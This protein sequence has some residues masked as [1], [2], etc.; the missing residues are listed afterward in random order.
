MAD[1]AP[2]LAAVRGSLT[3]SVSTLLGELDALERIIAEARAEVAALNRDVA[4][5]EPIPA[6][7][8][9]LGAVVEHTAQATHTILDACERLEA[10]EL[11]A[12]DAP[13]RLAEQTTRIYE[14]CAFQDITGQRI[15]KVVN[16]LEAIERRIGRARAGLTTEVAASP[17]LN[18]PQLPG[19]G[20]S[21]S[22]I[23]SLFD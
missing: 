12:A 6:A 18:G 11:G 21:Q 15:A 1:T 16:A 9:E 20:I 2:V 23:D 3:T 14:A 17:L 7:A 5:G 13:L 10:L 4:E 19:A 8:D 22:D